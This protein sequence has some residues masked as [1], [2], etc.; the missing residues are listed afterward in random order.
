MREYDPFDFA[1]LTFIVLPVLLG[2]A[3]AWAAFL[4]TPR[5]RYFGEERVDYLSAVRLAARAR[6][7]GPHD[8]LVSQQ[9]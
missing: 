6:P 5:F 9:V 2:G 7:F 1:P 3:L 8:G 4:G